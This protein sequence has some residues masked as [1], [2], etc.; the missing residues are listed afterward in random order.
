MVIS[1]NKTQ[2]ILLIVKYLLDFIYTFDV[3]EFVE[4]GD[5]FTDRV[6]E[7]GDAAL[8]YVVLGYGVQGVDGQMELVGDVIDEIDEEMVAV[9]GTN[10]NS[11]RILNIRIF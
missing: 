2:I 4:Y 6:D 7:E 1:N 9:D 5:E 10:G 8:H 3:V 11:D